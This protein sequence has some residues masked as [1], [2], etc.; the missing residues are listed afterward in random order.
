MTDTPTKAERLAHNA[1]LTLIA[2]AAMVG[3]CALGGWNLKTTLDTQSAV[4]R[5]PDQILIVETRLSARIATIEDRQGAQSRRMD[6]TDARIERLSEITGKFAVDVA[7][8]AEQIKALIAVS[9]PI[10]QPR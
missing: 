2:R 4:G 7:V 9:K 8:L 5:V 10:G 1:I 3:A 6:L